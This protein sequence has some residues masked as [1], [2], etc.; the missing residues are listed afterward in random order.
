MDM[1]RVSSFFTLLTTICLL[2]CMTDQKLTP[3]TEEGKNTF[4]CK[5]N[6]KTW[7]PDGKGDIFVSVK[8]ITGG[9]L[10]NAITQKAN[11]H[12]KSYTSGGDVV[13]I[14][15]RSSVSGLNSLNKTTKP[16]GE[17]STP[18]TMVFMCRETKKFI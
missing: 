13:E 8:A 5:V 2:G 9:F 6:G 15:T 3:I 1:F 18:K 14:Y 17:I 7:I 10:M 11:I 4:S 12:I 16:R